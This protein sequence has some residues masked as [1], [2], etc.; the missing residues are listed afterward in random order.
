MAAQMAIHSPDP[1]AQDQKIRTCMM[2]QPHC[3]VEPDLA[4]LWKERPQQDQV[5]PQTQAMRPL[6]QGQSTHSMNFPSGQFT[7]YG[8]AI[9]S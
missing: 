1:Y 9:E 8:Q 2:P 5:V 3:R 7:W 4:T 6:A